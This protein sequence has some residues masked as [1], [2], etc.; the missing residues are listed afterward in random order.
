MMKERRQTKQQENKRLC[1][2]ANLPLMKLLHIDS[3]E[4]MVHSF[5]FMILDPFASG[6]P[7]S[8][9]AVFLFV[10]FVYILAWPLSCILACPSLVCNSS[11]VLDGGLFKL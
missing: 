2:K 10:V 3:A 5:V 7:F 8:G 11:G 6:D 1:A 9:N 4:I